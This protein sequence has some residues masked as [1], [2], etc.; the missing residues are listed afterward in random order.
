LLRPAGAASAVGPTEQGLPPMPG[1]PP[2]LPLDARIAGGQP[3]HKI[4]LSSQTGTQEAVLAQAR[5]A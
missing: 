5:L 4:S 2:P 1:L 3:R